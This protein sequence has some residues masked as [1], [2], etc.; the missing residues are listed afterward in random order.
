MDAKAP[1][2]R[3]TLPLAGAIP[4]I[5]I[6][7]LDLFS[8]SEWR[9]FIWLILAT[10][11]ATHSIK[12]AWRHLPLAGGGHG[13][14]ALLAAVSSMVLA[15]FIWPAG[16]GSWIVAGIVGGPA[17]NLTFKLGFGLLKRYM[18]DLA[19]T[20]NLD[21]RKVWGL[22]PKDRKPWRKEDL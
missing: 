4:P 10:L 22:P 16:S 1:L 5:I 8:I 18:P 12:L 7:F 17:A 2:Q 20:V 14:V 13:H 6:W 9:A 11:G 19:A 21:R 3:L 15:Y